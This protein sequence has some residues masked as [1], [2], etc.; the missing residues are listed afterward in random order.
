MVS[1]CM[2]TYNHENFIKEAIEGV[3][4]QKCNFILE[5]VIGE[6]FSTDATRILCEFYSKNN[7]AIKLLP[8]EK[9]IG[10]IPNLL[11]TIKACKGKYIAICE[12]DDFWIDPLKLQKQFDYLELHPEY[13]LSYH[14]V[15]A[16]NVIDDKRTRSELEEEIFTKE[17]E[18]IPVGHPTHTSS[19]LFRN[20]IIN[21]PGDFDKIISGDSYLQFVLARYGESIFQKNIYPNIRR[22]HPQSVWS[23]KS[24]EYKIEQRISLYEKL[25]EIAINQKE[26]KY[27]N[28]ILIKNRIQ[29]VKYLWNNQKKMESLKYLNKTSKEAFKYNLFL[30]FI[31]YN[32]YDLFSSSGGYM[33][34]KS[35]F[36]TSLK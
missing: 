31:F 21:Y 14:N 23:Y 19:M 8:S 36:R 2:I 27:L 32:F 9:N 10:V 28:K 5:L 4:N 24:T 15:V 29:Y 13:V 26:V 33:F 18:D 25:L 20:I 6:D 35:K 34:L 1:V 12:G 22:R 11:R 17:A 7:P 16:I 3:L 30:Y